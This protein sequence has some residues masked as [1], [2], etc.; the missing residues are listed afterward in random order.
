MN[1]VK[2][3]SDPS[4]VRTRVEQLFAFVFASSFVH[5]SFQLIAE[6]KSMMSRV[7]KSVSRFL[8][9]VCLVSIPLALG[10]QNMA[11]PVA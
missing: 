10:A 11:K 5:L 3:S 7:L 9:L 8:A 2:I 4:R 6:E 1:D